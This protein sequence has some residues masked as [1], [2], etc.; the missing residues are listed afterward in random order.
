VATAL[1]FALVLDSAPVAAPRR[2]GKSL[3]RRKR[4]DGKV[5]QKGRRRSDTWRPQQLAYLRIWIDVPGVAESKREVFALG[6]C[7]SRTIAE[8][9]AAEKIEKLGINSTRRFIE[10]TSQTTFKQ[11]GERWLESLAKR[12]RN[13]LEQTTIDNRKYALD[14]W[15]YPFLGKSQSETSTI[16][17]LR[18]WSKKW[19]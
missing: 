8:R 5:F 11:Q 4:Q 19:P 10:T 1:Q 12:K 14:K 13:P 3:T 16:E 7:Q 18:S 6:I 17:P 2:R 9:K 15:I